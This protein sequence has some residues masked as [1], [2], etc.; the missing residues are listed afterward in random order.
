MS[1]SAA[2]P[3]VDVAFCFIADDQASGVPSQ[4]EPFV[5]AVISSFASNGMSVDECK[6]H[7]S[8][9]LKS[10]RCIDR[11]N[12][13]LR[14][15]EQPLPSSPV[16]S[17]DHEGKRRPTTWTTQEDNRLLC[18]IHRFGRRSWP[19]IASFVGNN[20]TRSQCAQRWRRSLD[21]R[22]SK[23]QWT[24]GEDVQLIS[25]VRRLGGERWTSISQKMGNRSDVQCRYRYMQLTKTRNESQPR[26]QQ[27]P[28][29]PVLPP[30]PMWHFP[31]RDQE[32]K[33]Q[34]CPP[35]TDPSEGLIDWNTHEEDDGITIRW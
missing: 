18:A 13:I 21:P 11:L 9:V 23:N 17:P 28:V 24:A 2:S 14:C 33:I 19:V 1:C 10:T 22:L 31:F 29:R 12:V 34:R 30:Q 26:H 27:L 4:V 20:R 25:L 8:P 35:L 5:R 6:V 3:L 16:G 15:P 32:R 7:L